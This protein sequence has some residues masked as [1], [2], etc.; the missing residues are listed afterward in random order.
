MLCHVCRPDSCQLSPERELW[1]ARRDQ[2]PDLLGLRLS[3][4]SATCENAR[5][6]A[7]DS[8]KAQAHH[9]Y[10]THR[11]QHAQN[12]ARTER[13]KGQ[14]AR[15]RPNKLKPRRKDL[16]RKDKKRVPFNSNTESSRRYPPLTECFGHFIHIPSCARARQ[17]VGDF[18]EGSFSGEKNK[19]GLLPFGGAFAPFILRHAGASMRC[20][21]P[22]HACE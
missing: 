1:H 14:G 10:T 12:A 3:C 4:D 7:N 13:C 20:S 9:T 21:F 6:D 17:P 15:E 19:R 16:P 2:M 11:T 8:V 22:S 18:W 5:W